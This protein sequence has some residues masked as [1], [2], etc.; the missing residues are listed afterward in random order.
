VAAVV[1]LAGDVPPELAQLPPSTPFPK[2]ALLARGDADTWYDAAK[3]TTDRERLAGRGVEIEEL[4]FP[5]GHEWTDPFR[6]ATARL[7]GRV[8]GERD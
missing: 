5:G 1:A 4:V 3:L 6:E 2:R 7:L 8:A